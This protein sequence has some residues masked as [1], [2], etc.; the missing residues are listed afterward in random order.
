[1]GQSPEKPTLSFFNVVK[2]PPMA[3]KK[4]K[5]EESDY[6]VLNVVKSLIRDRHKILRYRSG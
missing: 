4:A 5:P 1:M 2:N 3:L 6:V